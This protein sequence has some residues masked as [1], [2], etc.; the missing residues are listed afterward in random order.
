MKRGHLNDCKSCMREYKRTAHVVARERY[1]IGLRTLQ[2]IGF[3]T[4]LFVY[5]RAGRKCEECGNE[6]DLCIH[7]LDRHGRNYDNRGLPANNDPSN[8]QILC[9]PCHGRLHGRQGKGIPHRR[10]GEAA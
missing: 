4:A 6:Y 1:G 10:I 9:R 5:D 7:H 8:L 3:K 2:R